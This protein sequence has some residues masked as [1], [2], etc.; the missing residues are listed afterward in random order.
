[1][2]S[3]TGYGRA[4]C[5]FNG[6]KLSVEANSVNRKQSDVTVT[7][8]RELAALEPRLRDVVYGMIAR[9]RLSVTV[10]VA[11]ASASNGALALDAPLA[12]RYLAAMR[13][14]QSALKVGGEITI[15]TVLRAPGVLRPPEEHLDPDSAWP[16][17]EIAL[18]DALED[19]IKMREK[20]GR[21][22]ARDLVKRLKV[23]RQTLRRIRQLHPAVA[24][25]VRQ[26]LHERLEKAGFDLALDDER[27]LKE[28]ALFADRSEIT[29]E[30]TRLESHLA[31]FAHTLRKDG[32]VGR[33]LDFMIQEIYR[34]LNTL[35]AK[36]NDAAIS[37]L[38]VICK[39]EME[40]IREQV[41]NIE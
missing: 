31:Q 13:E 34:E 9:G 18:R 12:K 7:L 1:M 15:E 6:L 37:Q 23:V 14:L 40:K 8:P 30:L 16:H 20:E 36:A 21:H 28:V 39:A 5:A 19:L 29:E 2:R 22:L 10:T 38:V 24:K 41:Q 32:P 35:G 26:Q 17:L 33:T 11:G 3:M 25:R 4:D 27:L